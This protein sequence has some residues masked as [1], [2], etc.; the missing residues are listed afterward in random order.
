M[1]RLGDYVHYS[2]LNY[3]Q[4]GTYVKND[5]GASNFNE[6]I[7]IEHKEQVHQ[8][9]LKMA[10]NIDI[11]AIEEKYNTGAGYLNEFLEQTLTQLKNSDK[12][13]TAFIKRLL[14]LINSKWVNN[15]DYIAKYLK[16][17]QER[18]RIIYDPPVST[19]ALEAD[20]AAANKLIA[21]FKRA[22]G[23]H[24]D[25]LLTHLES[26]QAKL[27]S[28]QDSEIK[29][30]LQTECN[31]Y[32]I[33][34]N[35]GKIGDKKL[36]EGIAAITR[37]SKSSKYKKGFLSVAAETNT[38]GANSGFLATL[39]AKIE[40]L[41]ARSASALSI[42]NKI[43][44]QLAE[45]IGTVLA[46]NLNIACKD[47]VV[48]AFQEF[49]K[50]GKKTA[51]ASSTV[52]WDDK[53]LSSTSF[54][55]NL[56]QDFMKYTFAFDGNLSD[57][58]KPLKD[59]AGNIIEYTIAPF[60]DKVQQKADFA[61]TINDHDIGVSMKNYD[62][63]AIERY[64][65]GVETPIP[66]GIHLQNSSLLLYL[67]GLELHNTSN[68]KL[69][70]H[71]LQILSRQRGYETG[72]HAYEIQKMRKQ[73]GEALSLYILW[74]AATGQGQG[75]G[76]EGQFADILAIYD[77]AKR[78]SKE[79]RR[80]RLYSMRDL[81]LGLVDV[82][83]LKTYAL[84]SPSLLEGQVLL[85]NRRVGDEPSKK[86]AQTRITEMLMQARVRNI[87]ASLSKVYLNNFPRLK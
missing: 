18:E 47:E 80:I 79:F 48:T 71:Y 60:V 41:T 68:D 63:S 50:A 75:R 10:Q 77:K 57:A 34:L 26:I 16:Y 20:Q 54:Y 44:A 87:S 49:I 86:D 53:G 40:S 9:I 13:A 43:G 78:D 36:E 8:D 58:I 14:S 5:V 17:D 28:L 51:G 35:R 3:K 65:Q 67:S 1:S 23:I 19:A 31:N 72:S 25:V 30:G 81:L 66:N 55:A 27:G 38:L 2:W 21:E 73:A 82:D 56:D 64:E 39:L 70:T 29:K 24:V 33:V 83:K 84:F 6:A 52:K 7:F 15:V 76:A 69:G 12:E 32:I 4:F 22:R 59:K 11:K 42:Q 37:A 85:D 74:S 45:I 46:K 62:M 61:I